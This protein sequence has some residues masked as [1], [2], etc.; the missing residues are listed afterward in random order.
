MKYILII[1][2]LSGGRVYSGGYGVGSSV[3]TAEFNS[4][5]TCQSAGEVW[6]KKTSSIGSNEIPIRTDF[7]CAAKGE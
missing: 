4:Y 6:L 3:A 1:T 5:E 7:I 2:L